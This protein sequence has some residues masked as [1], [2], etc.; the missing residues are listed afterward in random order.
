MN[1]LPK[2]GQPMSLDL[3]AVPPK[4]GPEIY[5][6]R[7]K[8]RERF[9]F[10]VFSETMFGIWVH[11]SHDRSSPHF[12]DAK[13]CPGCQRQEPKRWKGFLHCFCIEKKQEVFL[14]LTPASAGSLLDQLATGELLRGQGIVVERTKGDNGRVLVRVCNTHP[15]PSKLPPALDPQTSLLALWGIHAGAPQGG[16]EFPTHLNGVPTKN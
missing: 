14:E 9:S 1:R 5:I 13:R 11:W 2:D 16:L 7:L 10:T 3:Q 8:G 15:E 4:S 6:L 12:T